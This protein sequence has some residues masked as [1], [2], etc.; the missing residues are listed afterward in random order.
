[1]ELSPRVRYRLDRYKQQFNEM[2]SGGEEKEKPRP[3]L[4]P[5]CGT[6]VGATAT[7]CYSCGANV[8]FGMAA[9]RKSL[10]RLLPAES[11]VTYVILG[12]TCIWYAITFALTVRVSGGM[13]APGGAGFSALMNMGGIN[14]RVLIVLGGSLP[15]PNDFHLFPW[16]LIMPTLLHG[17]LL[18]IAFNMWV[19]MDVGPQLEELYGSARYLFIYFLTG[20][21]AYLVSGYFNSVV[22]IGA[23]G[24][25]LGL[26]GVMLAIT[27]RRQGEHMR[28]L[29]SSL[30]RWVIYIAV[31]G[32]M[33]GGVDNWAHGGGLVTGFIAGRIMAD[34]APLSPAEDRIAKFLGWGTG[35]VVFGCIAFSV[36]VLYKVLMVT[37]G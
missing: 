1:L 16:R 8:N 18:H 17:G 21:G 9:A 30:I 12:I 20:M 5:N 32:F 19:L 4:C 33:M 36:V 3:R 29:R 26:I 10:G 28:M 11:P 37:R 2:F 22:A 23:S 27:T 15:W 25:L 35:I 6:L 34:R 14:P 13:Q 7:K 31:L 24:A